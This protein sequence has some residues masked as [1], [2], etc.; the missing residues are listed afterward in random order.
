MNSVSRTL[1]KRRRRWSGAKEFIPSPYNNCLSQNKRNK[2]RNSK[3]MEWMWNVIDSTAFILFIDIKWISLDLLRYT[4]A[5][6]YI[7]NYMWHC[8]CPPC[9]ILKNKLKYMY[10]SAWSCREFISSFDCSGPENKLKRKRRRWTGPCNIQH[11]SCQLINSPPAW[12]SL[13]EEVYSS[14]SGLLVIYL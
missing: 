5:M 7:R 14:Y 11:R 10:S 3:L 13:S 9:R 4:S 12:L 8:W 2:C 1:D 6:P